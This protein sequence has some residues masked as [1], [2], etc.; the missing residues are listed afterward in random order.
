MTP[1]RLRGQVKKLL[2]TTSAKVTGFQSTIGA[3]ANSYCK[4]MTGKY[5]GQWIATK[6]L[7]VNSAPL[8]GLCGCGRWR[9]GPA[10]RCQ[11]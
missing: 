10:A 7:S 4:F 6:R 1:T 5:L 3:N 11:T 9:W 8:G 2:Q